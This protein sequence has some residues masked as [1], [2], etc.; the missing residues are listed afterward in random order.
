MKNEHIF[1]FACWLSLGVLLWGTTISMKITPIYPWNAKGSVTGIYTDGKFNSSLFLDTEEF[2]SKSCDMYQSNQSYVEFDYYS[3][4]RSNE[5]NYLGMIKNLK[6]ISLIGMIIFYV[7]SVALAYIVRNF[8]IRIKIPVFMT[9]FFIIL[10]VYIDLFTIKS[11]DAIHMTLG[12]QMYDINGKIQTNDGKILKEFANQ[13]DM[14]EYSCLF[15]Y[16]KVTFAQCQKIDKPIF[17]FFVKNI[18]IFLT[19]LLTIPGMLYYVVNV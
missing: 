15:T 12:G 13:F 14:I 5:R 18:T 1:F 8:D 10:N 11:N 16:S 19:Y 17:S 3:Y 6:N 9:M 4:C 7:I 2:F